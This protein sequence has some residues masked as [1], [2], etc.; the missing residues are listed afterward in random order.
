MQLSRG[1][2]RLF[3]LIQSFVKRYGRP[4]FATQR[5]VAAHFEPGWYRGSGEML[6]A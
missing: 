1:A 2:R 6:Y 5:W 4:F 3:Q